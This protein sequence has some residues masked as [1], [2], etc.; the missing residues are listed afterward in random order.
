MCTIMSGIHFYLCECMYICVWLCAHVY[1]YL[2]S[3]EGIGASLE[4]SLEVVV[5]LG[6]IQEQ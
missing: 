1:K 3:P 5:E 4:L 2:W 6:P